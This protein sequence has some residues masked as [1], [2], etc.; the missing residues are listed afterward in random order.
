MSSVHSLADNLVTAA[1][2]S[3]WRID[4]I[5]IGC[6]LWALVSGYTQLRT[7]LA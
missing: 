5:L 4:A 1:I 6:L 2:M 7:V 3:G